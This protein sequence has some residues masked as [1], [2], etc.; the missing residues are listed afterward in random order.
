MG[1][2]GAAGPQAAPYLPNTEGQ[3]CAFE[4]GLNGLHDDFTPSDCAADPSALFLKPAQ[5]GNLT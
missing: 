3:P 2:P 4:G 5:D 1:I